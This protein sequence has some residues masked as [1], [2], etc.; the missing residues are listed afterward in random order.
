MIKLEEILMGR[1][2]EFPLDTALKNNL[3]KLH[4]ALN[5]FRVIYGKPMLVT[6]GYR[7]G[8]Y[9]KAAGGA[10]K[11]NHTICL[12]CDFADSNGDLDAFC[13]AN[14][15]VLEECGLYLE[16]PK[17]TKGW[18]HLQCVP[19]KS[20]N[21]IFILYTTEPS[22][23]KFDKRFITLEPENKLKIKKDTIHNG[24]ASNKFSEKDM[25][26]LNKISD[27]IPIITKA[28]KDPKGAI[29]DVL[30]QQFGTADESEIEEKAKKMSVE[31]LQTI[32]NNID[33]E[34]K[35]LGIDLEKTKIEY[36][37]KTKDRELES[38]DFET[39]VNDT[40]DAREFFKDDKR[41]FHP[42]Y[43]IVGLI[44]AYGFLAF[45]YPL[46]GANRDFLYMILNILSTIVAGA[47]SYHYG[48]SI[49]SKKNSK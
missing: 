6:S 30:L 28:I 24:E 8:E 26:F 32:N 4:E 7:P 18:C 38:K 49:G 48:V 29:K 40:H 46:E 9:N 14:P 13:I 36:A 25:S 11:S 19:P 41:L 34:L 42:I 3:K 31:E 45:K 2:K 44:G 33:V 22:E 39:S 1:D 35:K 37:Y 5:K 17:W 20:G 15:E 16:H 10:N 21:R 12:A 43:I 27:Y 23:N 47:V